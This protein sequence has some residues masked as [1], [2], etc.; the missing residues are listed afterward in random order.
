MKVCVFDYKSGNT[1]SLI[2]RLKKLGFEPVLSNDL[3]DWINADLIVFPGV[4]HAT[5]VMEFINKT[6]LKEWI[7]KY[8]KPILGICL[9]MQILCS[10]SEEGNTDCLGVFDSKIIRFDDKIKSPNM[11]WIYLNSGI[12]YPFEFEGWFYF[13]HS[14]YLPQSDFEWIKADEP[15]PFI[16]A[17]ARDNFLGVQFHP[18]KSGKYG[19][20]FFLKLKLWLQSK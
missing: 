11:G 16:A 7:Q 5:K 17:I 14:Y 20:Q 15:V 1:F 12:D 6:E 8:P 2:S 13:V 18:E 9:G 10:F 19:D 3:F 4:G